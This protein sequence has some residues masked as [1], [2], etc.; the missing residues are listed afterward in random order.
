VT[1]GQPIIYFVPVG[2]NELCLLQHW[3]HYRHTRFVLSFS[4]FLY[5][6]YVLA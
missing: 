6:N 3:E 4:E 2:N 5:F 1:V